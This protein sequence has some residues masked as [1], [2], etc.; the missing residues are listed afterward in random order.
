MKRVYTLTETIKSNSH[1]APF[2]EELG[3]HWLR[4]QRFRMLPKRCQTYYKLIAL[5]QIGGEGRA[6]KMTEEQ[7]ECSVERKFDS[8]DRRLMAGKL[9]QEEYDRAADDI[10]RWAENE[11][12]VNKGGHTWNS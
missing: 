12:A 7:I 11:Y 9:T 10:H 3:A 4:G 6:T 2:N 1:N 8:L 5:E